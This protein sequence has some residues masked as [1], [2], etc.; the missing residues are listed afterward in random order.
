VIG[1][2]IEEALHYTAEERQKIIDSY[3]PHEREC[4]TKGIPVLGSGRI[5]PIEESKIACEHREFPSHWPRIGGMDF[6]WDHPFAAVELVHDRDTDTVYVA[7][8]HRLKEA[9]PIEHAAAIRSWQE[10]SAGGG[11]EMASGKH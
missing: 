4:R 2:T 3:P 5:F 1:M 7:R 8:C 9:S 10:I 6:G 11:L